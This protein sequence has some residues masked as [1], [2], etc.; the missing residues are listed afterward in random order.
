[1]SDKVVKRYNLCPDRAKDQS[2]RLTWKYQDRQTQKTTS[3]RFWFVKDAMIEASDIVLGSEY[4]QDDV[5]DEHSED[6]DLESHRDFASD[7][8]DG[9]EGEPDSESSDDED[10][11]LGTSENEPMY[12]SDA[13]DEDRVLDDDR[14]SD[15]SYIQVSPVNS[16]KGSLGKPIA[17]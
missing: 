9:E 4:D 2:I 8:E 6:L 16:V 13:D 7:I 15:D 17:I 1:M 10:P 5:S 3:T 11:A 12:G 14:H